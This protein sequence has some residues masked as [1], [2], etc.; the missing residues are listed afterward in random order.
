MYDRDVG[1]YFTVIIG[2]FYLIGKDLSSD[3]VPVQGC[4]WSTRIKNTWQHTY[5]NVG[6]DDYINGIPALVKVTRFN[7]VPGALQQ[8]VDIA[9]KV[10]LAL[11]DLE[12]PVTQ[13][14]LK[15]NGVAQYALDTAISSVQDLC[16]YLPV[17]QSEAVVP[18]AIS[19][20]PAHNP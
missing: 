1:F 14:A 15:E 19:L 11:A 18:S 2:C 8:S 4:L 9:K 5:H 16:N 6:N 7:I 10:Q 13:A 12:S 3:S 20:H 17:E